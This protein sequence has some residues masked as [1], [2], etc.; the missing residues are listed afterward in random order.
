[1]TDL[2]YDPPEP[3]WEELAAALE[4]TEQ[5]WVESDDDD[6]GRRAVRAEAIK[7]AHEVICAANADESD[8]DMVR[9]LF[10]SVANAA[11]SL[12]GY[13]DDDE[14][15]IA[16]IECFQIEPQPELAS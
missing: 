4:K 14:R 8:K 11:F 2:H 7:I 16:W 3:D 9:T 5:W 10:E 13:Y 1:M 15:L 12:K 6:G